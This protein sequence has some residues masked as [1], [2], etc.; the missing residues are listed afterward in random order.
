MAAPKSTEQL[1]SLLTLEEKTA[2]GPNGVR[3]AAIDRDIKSACFPAAC[4]VAA[5]FDSDIA[6]RVGA[7]LAAEARHKNA[8]CVLGPTV[9]IHRHPL[10]GR[11]FES[12]SEDPFLAGKLAAQVIH[13]LQ[14]RG[15]SATIKHF[16]ANEQET[17]RTTVDEIIS[18]RALREIYLR[19]FEI[20]IREAHPWAVMTAYNCV[21][22]T[23]CDSNEWLLKSVLRGEW[24]WDGL[25]ISD[26]GGTNSVSDALNAGLDLEMPGPPRKRKFTA[27]MDA[28]E[29]GTLTQA[30][31]DERARSIIRFATK[32]R[33]LADNDKKEIAVNG[34]EDRAFIREAGARG[35]VL[36]KNEQSI[37]PL[38]KRE[39][40]GKKVALIGLAKDAL[41]HGGGSASVN[42]YYRV[43]PWEGLQAA[44]G[45]DVEL[46]YSKGFHKERL[47]P[48]IDGRAS[49]CGKI[50]GLDGNI[51]FSR[52]LYAFD[53][54]DGTTVDKPVSVLH[55]FPQSAYSPLGSQESLWKSLEIA[56]DFIP[57]ETGEH[58]I[59]CSGLGPTQILVD[60]QVIFDQKENCSDPMGS[61]FLAAPEVEIRHAFT[62]GQTYRLRIR[63]NPPVGI[64]L[65]ILEGRSG[66]RMGMSLESMHDQDLL[67]E[68]AF[69]AR[70]ADFA[71]VFTGHDPQWE[72]EGRDQDS[73]HLP[74][75][76]TQDAVVTAV[77]ANNSNTIVVNSTGVA[78]AMPWLQSVRA[79]VQSWFP[80]QECGNSIA[81]ILTGAVNP[82]GRLPV[83][84]PRHIEDAP[85]HGN[86][87]GGYVDGQLKVTYAE[88][89][90]VGYRHYD[91]HPSDSINFPFGH[92]LSYT[93]F[94]YSQMTVTE[95]DFSSDSF[96]VNVDV[97]NAGSV[98]GGTVIQLYL[99]LASPIPEHPTKSLVGFKKV[100]IEPDE[101]CLVELCISVRDAAYFDVN[102]RRW[103][104]DAGQY[105]LYLGK[106]AAETLQ[107]VTITL[108]LL[109]YSL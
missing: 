93:K 49:E 41:A 96:V 70:Q 9:C 42:T 25:V 48:P 17:A 87:P 51:G 80:G 34:A 45:A 106:S 61:L 29:Q 103:V 27:I 7:S 44:L 22:G 52:L 62:A 71:I 100:R 84:F 69:V 95:Y 47:L 59:A 75:R 97:S 92:G 55:D 99:G 86:F 77:A 74:R 2:D 39:L 108:P 6:Y 13:G 102:L 40:A 56:G 4:S 73:F 15:V 57:A 58:Y 64:G 104:V 90:F 53:C 65:D 23:H 66:V 28:L 101:S 16:V 50:I 5:S 3:A 79:V 88:D 72:S 14:H 107:T 68:A 35:I 83:T 20:A 8:H 81:D 85:A 105:I 30:K 82:E 37:L 38:S 67:G 33:A 94:R 89:V 109:Q 76:G 54:Q 32:I 10:G 31:I 1:L 12:F 98:H 60:D 43:T 36:L 91:K 78:I 46:L 26:W 19:P 18:E 24:K 21:N 63:T 11:N